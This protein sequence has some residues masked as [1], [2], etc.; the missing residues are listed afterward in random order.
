MF[1]AFI[2]RQ[3]IF[4]RNLEVFAYE[5]LYRNGIDNEANVVDGDQ[6]TSQVIINSFLD[7]GLNNI[8]GNQRAFINLTHDF[9]TGKNPIPYA[10][11]QVIL[12]IL[13]DIEADPAVIA[14]IQR[15]SEK[16][17]IMAL[18]DFILND[19][20]QPLLDYIDVIKIDLHS[21]T[22]EQ[23]VEHI[24]ILKPYKLKLLAEKV[25]TQQEF[26]YCKDIGFDYFQGYFLCKPN[27]IKA[28][29]APANRLAIMQ[30]LSK[31]QDPLADTRNLE[32][33][34]THEVTLSYKILRS[35]NSAFYALPRVIESIHQAVVYLG[36]K[37]IKKLAMLII[38]SGVDD[39][40]HE[41]IVTALM[42]SRMCELL[43][44]KL[45]ISDTDSYSTAGLLSVLDAL[46]DRP[47]Q[48][49][50]RQLPLSDEINNALQYYEG[51]LGNILKCVIAYERCDWEEAA[52]IDLPPQE[53]TM[54]Y[55]EAIRWVSV[56]H[57]EFTDKA[58][59][60]AVPA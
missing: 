2:G 56:I 16:G 10:P 34:I 53:L 1:D 21:S 36:N 7:I 45:G 17:Y 42:R 28:S 5:L 4:D 48:E 44:Q 60:A 52:N 15:L 54:C 20:R 12:E 43:A 49:L 29:R 19:A 33:L 13:E 46:M 40:P 51:R 9:V 35:I 6:A 59:Q 39:K 18:D 58:G 23:L 31:L 25:E 41:L 32:E 26:E 27:I 57:Q 38:L 37:A 3:P 8:V 14:G 22:D 11:N 30:I 55:L 50:L 47:M 24:K